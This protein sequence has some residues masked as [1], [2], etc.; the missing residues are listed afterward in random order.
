MVNILTQMAF[1][2]NFLLFIT[3]QLQLL[4][5]KLIK[6]KNDESAFIIINGR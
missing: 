4:Y 5:S 6:S 3:V 2:L 1:V